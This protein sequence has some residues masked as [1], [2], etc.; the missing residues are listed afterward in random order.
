[1]PNRPKLVQGNGMQR[2]NEK[3]HV[4]INVFIDHWIEQYLYTS[5][6]HL[7]ITI[8]EIHPNFP[9]LLEELHTN[10][11]IPQPK[12]RKITDERKKGGDPFEILKAQ[13]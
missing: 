5:R 4:N 7:Q 2:T 11:Q 3:K 12:N 8:Q 9:P 13:T 10:L 1:M 6:N